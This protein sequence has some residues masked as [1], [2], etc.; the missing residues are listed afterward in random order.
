VITELI[1]ACRSGSFETLQAA[2]D[3]VTASG[4]PGSE[5]IGRLHE[6]YV[7]AHDLSNY[8]KALISLKLAEADKRLSDRSDEFLVLL[9]ACA[10]YMRAFMGPKAMP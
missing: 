6:H 8:Q 5:I 7:T 2:I 9:D 10:G 4:Y 1:G 3:G